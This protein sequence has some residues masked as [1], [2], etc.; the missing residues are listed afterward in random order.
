MAT[1]IAKQ[2][3]VRKIKYKDASITRRFISYIIDW[4]VGA[5]C[6]AIPISITSQKLSNTM[7]NQYIVE[8]EH[9]FGLIAGIFAILFAIFYY[10]IVPTYINPGQTLGKKICKIKMVQ[11]DDS[12]VTLKNMLLRQLLGIIVIEGVLVTASAIWHQII[13]IITQINFVTPLMYVGFVVTG[14]S[15][16]L[17]LFKG[18]RALHDYLGNTKV[19]SCK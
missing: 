15:V 11:M 5:L 14:I 18:H 8:F 13:T 7:L 4:Y 17:Y 9:P 3:R 1:K 16:L 19:V 10:V 2:K 12:E 6:T